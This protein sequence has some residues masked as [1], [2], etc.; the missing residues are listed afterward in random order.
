MGQKGFT[1]VELVIVFSIVALLSI[2][3]IASFVAFS[4]RQVLAN[5]IAE[6]Q[7]MLNVA[8]T[9][10][11]SQVNSSCSSS[12]E[13][14]GYVVVVCCRTSNDPTSPI[15]QIPMSFCPTIGCSGTNDYELY[16]SCINTNGAT[17]Y[18]LIQGKVLPKRV[19][20]SSQTSARTF[21][22]SPITGS[23]SFGGAVGSSGQVQMYLY[24]NTSINVSTTVSSIGTIQ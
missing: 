19:I 14:G 1:L 9:D 4:D 15:N 8:R 23:V 5:T 11:L 21:Q 13:F 2:A 17:R 3:G 20:I 16:Q 12:E 10:T 24:G 22:F 6:L 18:A 7:T